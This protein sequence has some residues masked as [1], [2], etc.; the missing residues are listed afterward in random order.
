MSAKIGTPVNQKLLTN[1]CL[2]RMKKGS[3]RFEL[4]AYPNKVEPWR[5]GM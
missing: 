2:V 1:V 5:S 3:T 4:A